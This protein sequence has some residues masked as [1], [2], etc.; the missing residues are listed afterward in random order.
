[1][2]ALCGV[3]FVY[4]C[5]PVVPLTLFVK[6]QVIVGIAEWQVCESFENTEC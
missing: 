2:E 4:L 3:L 6:S 5:L 1:M